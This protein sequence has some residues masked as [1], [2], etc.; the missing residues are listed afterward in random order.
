VKLYLSQNNFSH[1][2]Y[3]KLSVTYLEAP[4]NVGPWLTWLLRTFGTVH[5]PLTIG[6]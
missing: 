6:I 2:K 4:R 1:N 3:S 5:C